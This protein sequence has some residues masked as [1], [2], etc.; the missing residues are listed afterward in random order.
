MSRFLAVLVVIVVAVT[1]EVPVLAQSI[2][3]GA[4][5]L[6]IPTPGCCASGIAWADKTLWVV[7]RKVNKI[8]GVDPFTGTVLKELTA[9]GVQ[10]SGLASDGTHLWVADSESDEL[11]RLDPATGLVDR[12]IRLP[13]KAP[14]GLAFDGV[15]L[16]LA[17]AR[18]NR[19][20]LLDSEDGTVIRYFNSPSN[21]PTAI[22]FDGRYLW[23]ADRNMDEIYWMD[24]E[25]GEVLGYFKSPG[26]HPF[27][28]T[29]D[30]RTLWCADYQDRKIHR[31]EV[32]MGKVPQKTAEKRLTIEYS[33]RMQVQG[34]DPV[35][36]AEVVL[37]IPTSRPNQKIL[38]SP[39]FDPQPD[40][41]AV[42]RFGQKVAIFK[43]K[44]LPAGA[45]FEP[46]MIVDV[47]LY[48][49]RWWIQPDKVGRLQDI[50]R[51][52]REKYLADGR[53]YRLFDP[54]IRK[55]SAEAVGDER[56]PYWMAR[57]IYD[58]VGKHMDY[59]LAGGWDAAPHILERGSGSCSEYSF[60]FEALCRAA[61]IPARY[62]GGVVT[63]GDDAFVDNVFHRWTEIY[64]P[65]YG[66]IPVD[67]DRGDRESPRD[68]AKEFGAQENTLL[69]T[70]EN[71]GDSEYLDWK[72]NGNVRWTFKGRTS[73]YVE[74]IGELSPLGERSNPIEIQEDP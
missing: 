61:G 64:L 27:G 59:S 3:P 13:F 56:N 36:S 50:P 44:D 26:P 12:A 54:A 30:G 9:P 6:T 74:Q 20:Y 53:K 38:G 49:T 19:I 32:A 42:D 63:R 46:R 69:V 21:A 67:S 10:P 23:V 70:T 7:D 2:G 52:I 22:A 25:R 40:A 60:L 34:P 35:L 73:V 24:P 1:L 58:Y 72:Y 39:K 18:D 5:T 31:I 14:R 51:E 68:K 8:F 62:L 17:D 66:W 43:R 55:A 65:G 33:V 4:V 45:Q 15:N 16:Y 57:R 41:F 71:G 48:R 37:A 11:Y 29:W 47:A 28:L